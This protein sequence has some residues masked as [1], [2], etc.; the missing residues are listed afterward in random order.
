[1]NIKEQAK[2]NILDFKEV[3][4]RLGI[5]TCLQAGTLL[6][7]YRDKDFVVGDESDIDI[8]ILEK[9]YGR[10][11]ELAV[12]LEKVGFKVLK[13]FTVEDKIESVGFVRGENHLDVLSI[14]V[15]KEKA[16]NIGR[17]LRLYGDMPKIFAYVFPA[18]CFRKF[19]TIKFQGVDF[20]IPSPPELYLTAKYADW[21]VPVP[22]G[23]YNY[24]D[25][26]QAPCLDGGAWWWEEWRNNYERY[27]DK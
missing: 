22:R 5:F 15:R 9:D 16:F 14:H 23:E 2:E 26:K 24:L 12:E 11:K 25:T 10:I 18:A 20:N 8:A 17:N 3:V 6:G 13:T 21:K 7:A 1:M 4:D 19:E 27:P